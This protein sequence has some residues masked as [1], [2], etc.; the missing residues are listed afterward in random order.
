MTEYKHP[1]EQVLLADKKIVEQPIL[2]PENPFITS[3]K[4]FGL[5]ELL[6]AGVDLIATGLTGLAIQGPARLAV[7][8]LIGPVLEKGIFFARHARNAN[9]TY[10]TTPEQVRQTKSFYFKQ[11]IKHGSVNLFKD[12]TIHDPIYSLGVFAGLQYLPDVPPLVLSLTS[13]VIGILT[14]AGIDV[15]NGERKFKKL[16]KSLAQQGFSYEKYWESRFL[17]RA[18]KDPEEVM[19]KLS[20]EFGLTLRGSSKFQDIY[21]QNTLPDFNGRTG[22]LRLRS[23]GRREHEKENAKWGPDA[24][25]IHTLQVVYSRARENG[26]KHEQFNYFPVEKTKM[27]CFLPSRTKT[28]EEIPEQVTRDFARKLSAPEPHY[29]EVVFERNLTNSE[30]LAVCTDKVRAEKPCYL[31]ELKVFDNLNL[32][33]QAMRYVMLECPIVALQTTRGKGDIFV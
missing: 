4:D 13:Y 3:L 18:D 24:E 21:L 26:N 10:K 30:E 9:R 27:C 28:L 23:R 14:V 5:D 33:Q 31:L 12:L 15:V 6:C 16:K 8:P 32:L 25:A 20:E 19:E 22:K 17:I 2:L 1:L 7:L 11:G 29:G